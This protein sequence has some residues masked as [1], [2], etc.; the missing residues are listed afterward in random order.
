M[1]W[2]GYGWPPL[3]ALPVLIGM[4]ASATLAQLA[5]TRA[6]K[7]GDVLIVGSLSYS[8]VAFT[9]LLGILL[10]SE[11][12]APGEWLGLALIVASGVL[13]TRVG[14]RERVARA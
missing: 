11:W 10:W 4:G 7:E 2:Q 8:T 12:L 13:A 9:S 1:L 14:N 3:S 5:M 6:Y